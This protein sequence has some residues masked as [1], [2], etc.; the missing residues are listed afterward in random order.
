MRD[1]R[2]NK[3]RIEKDDGIESRAKSSRTKHGTTVKGYS[4]NTGSTFFYSIF[5]FDNNFFQGFLKFQK[6]T[7]LHL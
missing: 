7:I 4:S 5:D 3:H 6:M 2:V 1:Q